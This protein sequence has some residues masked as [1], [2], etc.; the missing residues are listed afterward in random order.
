MTKRKTISVDIK[1]Y[2]LLMKV[3]D[4]E[5]TSKAEKIYLI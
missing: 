5:E 3:R 1:K 2:I 4:E